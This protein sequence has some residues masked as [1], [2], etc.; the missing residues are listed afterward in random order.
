[1]IEAT[2]LQEILY[3]VLTLIAS[4]IIGIVGLEIKSYI[5]KKKAIMGYEFD[6]NRI[7]RIIDNAVDYAEI[8]GNEYLKVQSKKMAASDK[9]DAARYYVN[10]MDSR[11]I[12]ELGSKLDV[13]I[14][15]SINKKFGNG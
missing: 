8:K 5:A 7:N 6:N 2:A 4:G 14:D 11:K 13:M 3:Q 9:L 12:Q 15:R 1:M 10:K